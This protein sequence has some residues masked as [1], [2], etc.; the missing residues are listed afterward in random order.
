MRNTWSRRTR[1]D[2]GAPGATT[3]S[4]TTCNAPCSFITV[5]SG[6]TR[7]L[8]LTHLGRIKF[9]WGIFAR[10]CKPVWEHQIVL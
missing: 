4:W 1:A 8:T 3:S 9:Q 2:H 5:P 6:P 10:T 7:R